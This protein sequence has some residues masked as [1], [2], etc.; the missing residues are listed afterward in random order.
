MGLPAFILRVDEGAIL[1][2]S[3]HSGDT[4]EAAVVPV[5]LHRPWVHFD[6]EALVRWSSKILQGLFWWWPH[7]RLKLVSSLERVSPRLTCGPP[8]T[9]SVGLSSP[10]FRDL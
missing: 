10:P 9:M 5:L 2:D 4:T 3:A 8:F 7:E 6:S 1:T